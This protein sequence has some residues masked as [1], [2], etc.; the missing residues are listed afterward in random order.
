MAE[1]LSEMAHFRP[2]EE[3]VTTRASIMRRNI[4]PC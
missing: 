3:K 4:S 1:I 2:R